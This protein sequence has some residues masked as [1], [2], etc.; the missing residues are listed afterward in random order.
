MKYMTNAY[1]LAKQSGTEEIRE[2]KLYI[3]INS[4]DKELQHS[5]IAYRK[6]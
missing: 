2:Q 6:H 5:S 3:E 1:D 4:F